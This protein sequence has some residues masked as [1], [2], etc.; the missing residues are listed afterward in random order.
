MAVIVRAKIVDVEINEHESFLAL[1]RIIQNSLRETTEI[2]DVWKS[3]EQIDLLRRL[4]HNC[5]SLLI[6][7]KA[8]R[9]FVIRNA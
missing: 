9:Q 3:G 6:G 1:R 7:K 2:I 5:L 8:K 4:I